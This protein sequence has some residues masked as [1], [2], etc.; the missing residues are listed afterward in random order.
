MSYSNAV[1]ATPSVSFTYDTN[2]NRVLT[3]VDGVGTNVYSYLAMTNTVLGAGQ[4]ASVDGPLTNDTITYNYDALGRVTNRAINAVAQRVTS[5][6]YATNQCTECA[7][8]IDAGAASRLR[9]Q[10]ER[11]QRSA[12]S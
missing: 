11:K 6:L 5:E 8:K 10:H 2:Y 3:M 7:M 9:T 4:L 1:V 12:T